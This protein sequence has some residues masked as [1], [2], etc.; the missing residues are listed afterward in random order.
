MMLPNIFGNK[1][2]NIENQIQLKCKV[3]YVVESLLH[4]NYLN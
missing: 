2:N 4:I 1:F 3:F